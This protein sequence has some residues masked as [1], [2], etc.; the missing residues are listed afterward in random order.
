MAGLLSCLAWACS[1]AAIIGGGSYMH[2]AV[3][4]PALPAGWMDADGWELSWVSA[5]ERSQPVLALP[6][7]TVHL[8]LPRLEEAALLCSARFGSSRSLPFGALW[9]LDRDVDGTVR[10]GATGGYAAELAAT[11]YR[12]G[13][14]ACLLDMRRFV[15]ETVARLTD[16][17]DVDPVGLAT[18]AADR[19]FT[20]GYLSQP[21]MV[22]VPIDG[23][24]RALSPD[25]PWSLA[26][27]PDD[28]G[29]ASV[30]VACGRVRRWF[31]GGY[32]LAVGVSASGLASWTL[33]AA[34]SGM[35]MEKVL[36]EPSILV[37][38]ASPR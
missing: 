18:I 32:V 36:P 21:P 5:T 10:I 12:S 25:G 17:W 31:G 11:F 20:V 3:H 19:S 16:P 7:E 14:A 22:D 15:A 23:L 37:T 6:G 13:S 26:A 24:N 4:V 29:R 27:I 35:L 30:R 38:E 28:S 9:P 33:G 2:A 8:L 1:A 34:D